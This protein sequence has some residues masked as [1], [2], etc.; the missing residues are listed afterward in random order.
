MEYTVLIPPGHGEVTDEVIEELTAELLLFRDTVRVKTTTE[1]ECQTEKN[2]REV[3]IQAT[4]EIN[5]CGTAID[6]DLPDSPEM[7]FLQEQVRRLNV[8]LAEARANAEGFTN[9]L[10]EKIDSLSEKVSES[11]ELAAKIVGFETELNVAIAEKNAKSEELEKLQSDHVTAV[12]AKNE[13]LARLDILEKELQSDAIAKSEEIVKLHSEST[14]ALAEKNALV[15]NLEKEL[16][17]SKATV[18]A[19]TEELKKLEADHVMAI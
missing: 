14:T 9:P 4:A 11:E 5:S 13:L 1:K 3:A 19:K 8:D 17:A 6:Q 15:S 10:Q 12:A 2:S 16:E 7:I 18:N